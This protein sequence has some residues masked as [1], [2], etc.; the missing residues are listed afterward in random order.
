MGRSL[1][2]PLPQLAIFIAFDKLA[3]H[4]KNLKACR[5]I[6]SRQPSEEA[7]T[8]SDFFP[9]LVAPAVYVVNSQYPNIVNGTAGTFERIAAIVSQRRDPEF[10]FSISF[11]C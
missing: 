4:A 9:M 7:G 3:V 10:L 1:G 8:A 2:D 6:I 11:F 5:V